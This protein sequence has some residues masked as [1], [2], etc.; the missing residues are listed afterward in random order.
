[1]KS[2]TYTLRLCRKLLWL[3][4]MFLSPQAL[5]AQPANNLICNAAPLS[6]S[7]TCSYTGG[8]LTGATYTTVAGACGGGTPAGTRNDVWYSFVAKSTN[9]TITL[10]SSP[11]Q[12]SIQLFS[13][14]CSSPTAVQCVTST[15]TLTA[16]SLTI[17]NTYYVRIFSNNNTTGTFNI[18]ITDPAPSNNNCSASVPLLTSGVTCSPTTG[19]MYATTNSG[20]AIA[21]CTGTVTYD[22]WYRFT[23]QTPNPTVTISSLGTDFTNP[24]MQLLQGTCGSQT[25][26]FCGT[27]SIT[28][29]NLTVGTTY[30]VRVYSTGTPPTES[31]NAGFS[32]CVTDPVAPVPFNDECTGA[33]TVPVTSACSSSNVP[34]TVAGSTPSSIAIAPCTGPLGYDVWYRFTAV[35]PAASISL[36][37]VGGNFTGTRMQLLSG[38][39]G[40]FT[41]LQCGTTSISATGLTVGVTYYVRVYSTNTPAPN[42]NAGFNICI[43]SATPPPRFGNSYVNVSKRSTGG[44]VQ[45]GDTLE[46]RMT[47]NHTAGTLYGLRYVDNVPTHTNMLTGTQD[48]IRVITNEGLTF[49]R[50]SLDLNDD[51]GSYVAL[52]GPTEYNIR[53]NLGFGSYPPDTVADNTETETASA[54]GRMVAGSDRPR[55]GGGMLFATAFRVVVT[56]AVGDTIN[57]FP[58]KFIYQNTLGG[59]DIALTAVPYKI[60]IS[61]PMSL[62]TNATGVNNAQEFGGTFGTG[63]SLNRSTGLTYP[64]PGY[65][66]LPNVSATVGVGD[67]RY[68]IVKNISPRSGTNRN[69]ERTPTCPTSL[70]SQDACANRMHTGH[71]DIDGDHSGTSNSVGNTPEA[72]GVSGGY[73]LM[74]NADYVASESYRQTLNNLCPNTYY[75]FSAWFRN[76]CPTCGIDSL[77]NSYLP[78]QPG[79]LP[80]LTFA[81]DDL[82]RYSTGEMAYTG[83]WVKKGFMFVTGPAQTSATFIIRN[84][85]Q[86]GGGND[87]VM[88]DISIATCLPNM[89]YSPSLNPN[90]CEGNALTIY[91]TVRSYF[92]NYTHYIWQRSVNNGVSW[93]DVG[94]SGNATPVLTGGGLYEYITS[95]TI[96]HT[97]TTV[98]DSGNLY[99][100]IVATTNTNLGSTSCQVTDGISIINLAVNDCGPVLTTDLLAFNGKLVDDHASLFWS[101]SK[102]E[103]LVSYIVE[104]SLDGRSFYAIST[105]SGHHNGASVNTYSFKDPEMLNGKAWYRIVLNTESNR[106]KIS[107]VIQ[108]NR[109]ME[110]YAFGNVINPFSHT[111]RFDVVLKT[112]SPLTIDLIDLNGKLVRREKQLAYAGVNSL[113]LTETDGLAAGLYTLRVSNGSQVIT[114]RV[115]KSN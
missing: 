84:N 107:A 72:D 60:L 13:G 49:R 36:G 97:N 95:Y 24:G 115:M 26:L 79:V 50:Y 64:I 103:G 66:Y 53:L 96:P 33:I 34:G 78:R 110:A 105:L 46:I 100:V 76:I 74:V 38:T 30:Y 5:L 10:N 87:W 89:S 4:L 6:S 69:A 81:L 56:G 48:S 101:A 8:T 12:R 71:W 57:L 14:T 114:K 17:G 45:P 112:S 70:P 51:A 65:T 29:S 68:A 39:C 22:I 11:S 31:T 109:N 111:L 82:D 67:G 25:A 63:N 20:V 3:F 40:S 55:G 106:R 80:N 92:N 113:Q 35:D 93:T 21:P 41:S 73:M 18:C 104:K 99:R 59:A 90:V 98:S 2:F 108:L 7:P 47:I 85:S 91:D 54:I 58:G 32:I 44:V 19:N 28:A 77:G 88:D 42:A 43:T 1:M 37:S 94:T 16:S 61:D 27:T 86:G 52:P 15:S 75:E 83:G 62:C 9:P 23:A 102:E